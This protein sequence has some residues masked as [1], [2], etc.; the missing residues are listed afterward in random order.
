MNDRRE[1]I[2]RAIDAME[3]AAGMRESIKKATVAHWLRSL[4]LDVLGV[5]IHAI[6]N[7]WSRIE[8]RPTRTE[9]GK[10]LLRALEVSLESDVEPLTDLGMDVHS[11]ARSFDAWIRECHRDKEGDQ[12]AAHCLQWG[13]RVIAKLYRGGSRRVRLRLVTLLLEHLFED[14]GLAALFES[15]RRDK[16]LRR[17]FDQAMEWAVE[18]RAGP[19]AQA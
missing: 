17:A 8:P 11:A 12:E 13:I 6:S 9:F 10:A 4:D 7:H 15:W 3:F 16:V 2:A 5:V 1:D 14:E 19:S 18:Q